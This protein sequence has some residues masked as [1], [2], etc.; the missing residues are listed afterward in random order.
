LSKNY[1]RILKK[2]KKER[3]IFFVKLKEVG[4]LLL[5][6]LGFLLGV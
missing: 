2:R 6:L 4:F 5:L 3:E 1:S